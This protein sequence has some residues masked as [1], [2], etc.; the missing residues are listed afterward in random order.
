MF[1]EKCMFF[2]KRAKNEFFKILMGIWTL[3]V[4]DGPNYA[5]LRRGEC[6]PTCLDTHAKHKT[7]KLLSGTVGFAKPS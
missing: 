4:S 6:F 1:S 3:G 2:L 7:I 5:N